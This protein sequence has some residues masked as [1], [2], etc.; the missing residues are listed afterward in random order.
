[1]IQCI[2]KQVRDGHGPAHAERIES[3]REEIYNWLE[4]RPGGS[5]YWNC[6]SHTISAAQVLMHDVYDA[7]W[8]TCNVVVEYLKYV[9]CWSKVDFDCG[10]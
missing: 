3:K 4:E 8:Y 10:G 6:F 9:F 7:Y 2:A 5:C 1:M